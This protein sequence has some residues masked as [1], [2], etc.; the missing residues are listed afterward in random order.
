VHQLIEL[1]PGVSFGG[2]L[3]GTWDQ[4]AVSQ[5]V[6]ADWPPYW[7]L[8]PVTR[9]W[10]KFASANA[11]LEQGRSLDSFWP[12]LPINYHYDL[13]I[14]FECKQEAAAILERCE[15]V[16]IGAYVSSRKVALNAAW[17]FWTDKDWIECLG[18]ASR[19]I[20]D[21]TY[22]MIGAEYDAPGTR[23]LA[24]ELEKQGVRVVEC[25]GRPLGTAIEVI[26]R[27]GYL[28]AYPS[29]IGILANV[30]RTPCLMLLPRFLEKLEMAYA[31]PVDIASERY[32]AW[33]RPTP[34]EVI[35]WFKRIWPDLETRT[36]PELSA[37]F[38]TPS[39]T[40]VHA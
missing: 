34:E 22:V 9:P 7:G 24:A 25:L 33:A 40:E 27:L 20:G 6:P 39:L 3:E 2:Y 26:R 4:Q 36:L 32:R 10:K 21:M 14:P 37:R 1:L 8:D 31:D 15:G 5:S 16:P 28:F 29:G 18:N 17:W 38:A 13:D 23:K 30:L 12:L 19:V 11:H 35:S